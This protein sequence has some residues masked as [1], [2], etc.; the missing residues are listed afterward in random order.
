MEFL[1][2]EFTHMPDESY[3]RELGSS[4]KLIN[5]SITLYYSSLLLCLC[6]VFRFQDVTLVKF[7]YFEFT[8]M[9]GESYSRELRSLLSCLCDVCQELINSLVC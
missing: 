5:Q 2:L 4:I 9:P 1:Y 8:H 6:D 3:C 7:M